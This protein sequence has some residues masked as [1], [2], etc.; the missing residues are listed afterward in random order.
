MPRRGGSPDPP[1]LCPPPQKEP[2]PRN[3]AERTLTHQPPH[4]PHTPPPPP[5]PPRLARPSAPRPPRPRPLL[6]RARPPGTARPRRPQPPHRPPPPRLPPRGAPPPP[7]P[8]AHLRRNWSLSH[9]TRLRGQSP[10]CPHRPPSGGPQRKAQRSRFAL[11][12]RSDGTSKLC[13]LGEARDMQ[14]A[15]PRGRP[16]G[17]NPQR[18]MKPF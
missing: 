13:P 14:S 2:E 15:T 5:P 16:T 12:R 1:A 7:R 11:E 4:P 18:G 17:R 3:P 10:T 9:Q 6:P 8:P